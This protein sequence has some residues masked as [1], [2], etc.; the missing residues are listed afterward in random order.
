VTSL[1]ISFIQQYNMTL[2]ESQPVLQLKE[3]NV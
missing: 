2:T 3:R 1:V